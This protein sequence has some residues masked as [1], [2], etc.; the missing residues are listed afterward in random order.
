MNKPVF[1]R[2]ALA[3]ALC[4]STSLHTLADTGTGR[5]EIIVTA[6]RTPT[7][8]ADTLSSATLISRERIEALQP[9]DLTEVFRH[10]PGLDIS[11]S[12]GPGA[13]TSL[14]TR[15]TASGHTL[16][17][18]D[19]QRISS[20]TLGSSS[21]GLLNP[22]QIERV[23]VVRGSHSSLYGSD[24]IGGVIQI[25]TRDGSGEPGGYFSTDVGSHELQEYA[26]GTNGSSGSL[27]YG[28][29]LSYLDTDGIDNLVDDR[30]FNSDRDGYRNSSFNASVGYHFANDAD[31]A[32]R[33][34]ESD[35][36]NEHDSAFSPSQRPYTD[37]RLQNINLQGRLPVSDHWLSQLSLGRAV[38]VSRSYDRSTGLGTGN[39]RTERLQ[40]FWQNDL[41]LA[42]QQLLTLAWDYYR[43]EVESSSSYM[44]SA[45]GP[46][47]S[48]DNQA[49]LAEYQGSLGRL[50]LVLGLRQDDHQEFGHHRTGNI[51]LGVDLGGGLKLVG[52]WSEG[53]KAP[54]FNDLYWPA[55]SFSAGNPDLDPEVSENRELAL[56]GEHD[57][58][59]WSLTWFGNDVDDLI[60]W[61][62]GADLVW[63]PYNVSMAELR[64]AEFI[65]GTTL[66]GWLVDASYT[67]VEARDAQTN[68]L[69]PNR[70]RSNLVINLDR[71]L[72]TWTMGL[73]LKTQ[74][75]RFDNASNTSSL[76]GYTTVALRLSRQLTRRLQARLKVDNLFDRDYQLN[77]GY[78]QDGRN[79]LLGLNYSF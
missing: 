71:P 63:R 55:G 60:N 52:S 67:Y 20:A 68:R 27:R 62:P 46:V 34:L 64:G 25:F 40:L 45:G 41:Q 44:D 36:R 35:S 37:S 15:G 33:V 14:Y 8:L 76:G 6:T 30:G 56:K 17:L 13:A 24:A 11:R 70:A 72:G 12:G 43:D 61:A 4:L 23:E 29:N 3:V 50:D 77:E 28:I 66:A 42:E 31:I 73:S 19:G 22:Q 21:F 74:D 1:R 18:V 51:T 39:F 79:W 65:A 58:W 32:L 47:D 48:R 78:N 5:E 49:V 2:P 26:L 75:K 16:I 7:T 53:F 54:T 38:D 57:Q 59:H 69:L 10:A 9:L